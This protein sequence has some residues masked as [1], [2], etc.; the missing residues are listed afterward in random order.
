MFLFSM[1]GK[2]PAR[3]RSRRARRPRHPASR[4]RPRLEALETRLAPAVYNVTTTVDEVDDGTVADPAGADGVLS[5]REAILAANATPEAN[6]INLPS[7][8]IYQL[9]LGELDI[10]GG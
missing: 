3:S 7:G 9:A 2:R 5:L 6:T 4:F 1:S 10:I 8:S